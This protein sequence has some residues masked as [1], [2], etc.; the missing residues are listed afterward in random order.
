MRFS[1]VEMKARTRN[2]PHRRTSMGLAA[3]VRR[4][5]VSQLAAFHALAGIVGAEDKF[6]PEA[7]EAV[8]ARDTWQDRR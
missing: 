4:R 1:S 7:I 8:R 6:F 5:A 3:G 2:E